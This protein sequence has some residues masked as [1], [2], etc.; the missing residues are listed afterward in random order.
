MSK[1]SKVKTIEELIEFLND[2]KKSR[3]V[4]VIGYLNDNYDTR[5]SE[6]GSHSE[7][8]DMLEEYA[9]RDELEDAINTVFNDP[10][11]PVR[12]D[13]VEYVVVGDGDSDESDEEDDD[14]DSDD[15][16]EE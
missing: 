5:F 15:E 14:Y 9:D 6:S 3:T 10:F 4:S 12:N 11:S 7:L 13:P 16:S 1:K 2:H 8:L